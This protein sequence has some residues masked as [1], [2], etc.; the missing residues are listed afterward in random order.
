MD[1]PVDTGGFHDDTV[2]LIRDLS[3]QVAYYRRMLE[4]F[5]RD[6]LTGFYR[7]EKFEEYTRQDITGQSAAVIFFD[8]NDLKQVNDTQGHEAGDALLQ[9]AA[10]SIAVFRSSR[11]QVFRLGGDEFAAVL[12]DFE[13]NEIHD[14]ISCWKE[15]LAVLNENGILCSIAFGVAFSV[16][17]GGT[18]ADLLQ[19]ADDRMYANKRSMKT[20]AGAA[21]PR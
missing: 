15:R 8:V 4:I 9:K 18:F 7:R 12:L 19:K 14:V 20:E 17:D 21:L 16:E 2:G 1:I 5:E 3:M 11:S 13:L 6:A 10:E